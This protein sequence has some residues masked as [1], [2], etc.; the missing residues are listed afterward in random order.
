MDYQN[1]HDF[2]LFVEYETLT[3]NVFFMR[4][5]FAH[6]NCGEMTESQFKDIDKENMQKV[7][8]SFTEISRRYGESGFKGWYRHQREFW[9]TLDGK[10]YDEFCKIENARRISED[11]SELEAFLQE[12]G[13]VCFSGEQE[14]VK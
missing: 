10:S 7:I 13:Y 1:M 11:N 4:H 6:G 9:N 8:P 12:K 5:N 2:S 3:Y 14:K